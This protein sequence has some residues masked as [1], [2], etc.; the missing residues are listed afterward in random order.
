MSGFLDVTA[1]PRKDM[2]LPVALFDEPPASAYTTGFFER[3]AAFPMHFTFARQ[4]S[5]KP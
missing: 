2:I 3:A 1:G 5:A 4:R